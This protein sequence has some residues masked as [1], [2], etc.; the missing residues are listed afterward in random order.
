MDHSVVRSRLEGLVDDA[1]YLP[2]RALGV[3]ATIPAIEEQLRGRNSRKRDYSLRDHTIMVCS[4][5]EKWFSAV[6]L[7]LG[8]RLRALRLMLC[9]HDIGKPRALAE[10]QKGLQHEYTL[11]VWSDLRDA[12]PISDREWAIC[13]GLLSDDALGLYVR[14][15]ISLDESCDR[16]T[17]MASVGGR[18]EPGPFVD[19]L[20]IYYQ[21]DAGA[22]TRAAFLL[23]P[24]EFIEKPK[25]EAVFLKDA[26]GDLCFS[27]QKNR[28]VFAAPVE[29][30]HR[31]LRDR[32]SAG[33]S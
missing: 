1:A 27:P 24:G 19:L 22:Y 13:R 5:F 3:L 11:A 8:L 23:D 26:A 12:L 21:V 9:L 18:A 7:P 31:R 25:L 32:L 28:F 33:T 10:E 14:E 29:E 16:I 30:R 4:L 6:P 20:T 2:E 15:K 17:T